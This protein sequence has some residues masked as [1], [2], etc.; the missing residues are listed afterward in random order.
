MLTLGRLEPQRGAAAVEVALLH[1]ED[2]VSHSPGGVAPGLLLARLRKGQADLANPLEV[3]PA[4]GEGVG[5]PSLATRSVNPVADVVAC[6]ECGTKNRVPVAA[7]GTPRCG[8]C[9]AALAWITSAG[10]ADFAEVVER[11]NTPV[12]VDLWAP[13]CGPCRAVSPVLERLARELAGRV[14][15][16]KVNVDET[17]SLARRF[18]VKGIPTLLMMKRGEVVS[19][20]VGAGSEQALRDWLETALG[21]SS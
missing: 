15:L 19:R 13:W 7:S 20:Q 6:S 11:Q 1:G 4:G 8:H 16:V 21:A 17:P 14:K 5:T 10:E 9:G 12:L 18:G 2:P 3:V